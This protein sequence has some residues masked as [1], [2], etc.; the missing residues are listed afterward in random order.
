VRLVVPW[1][2]GQATDLSARLVAQQ[3]TKS[4]GQSV[5]IDNR[6]GAGGIIGSDIVA[7]APPD[8]YTL[9]AASSGPISINPHVQKVPYDSEKAFAPV[10][11]IGTVPFV[12]V[13]APS[14]PA[15]NIKQL[16][17]LVRASPGKYKFAS[18]G[19]GATAH[20]FVEYFNSQTQLQAIHVP[21]KGSVPALTDVINGSVDYTIETISAT[22][23]YIKGGRLKAFGVTAPSR[24]A[25]LP[26]V[27]TIA[28][29]A[30]LPGYDMAAWVGYLAP[31]GTPRAV[32]EQLSAEIQKALQLP[33]MRERYAGIGMEPLAS[34]PDDFGAF[35]S[36]EFARYGEIVKKANIKLD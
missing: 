14:F 9:L 28:E 30:D 10:S 2:P 11:L 8:G 26:E 3:L 20:L 17:T 19:T 34:R 1:P 36:K 35:T 18:S 5:V 25:S 32:R 27:P 12:L 4:L 24:L 15:S 21:Y 6:P 23:P 29:A 33:E 22:L 13:S 31:A 16:V 7:K